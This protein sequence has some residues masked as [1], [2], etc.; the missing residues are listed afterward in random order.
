MKINTGL[1]CTQFLVNVVNSLEK[2]FSCQKFDPDPF[3]TL[4]T[5]FISSYTIK[6]LNYVTGKTNIL[7]I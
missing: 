3:D 2:V 7:K 4:I 1:I 5:R 6:K